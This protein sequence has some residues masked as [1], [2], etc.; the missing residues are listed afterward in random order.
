MAKDGA[1]IA[2]AGQLNPRTGRPS[3]AVA[4]Q[5]LIGC[6]A[7]L[8]GSSRIDILLTGIAFADATFQAAVAIV[9]IRRRAARFAFGGAAWL[10][11]LIEVGIAI[12]CLVR[13]P[14]ESIYGVIALVVGALVWLVW[15]RKA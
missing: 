5:G 2:R 1:F 8:I 10:F 3:V 4:M 11:L 14:I 9:H 12:G 15:R 7:V 6:A 13:A